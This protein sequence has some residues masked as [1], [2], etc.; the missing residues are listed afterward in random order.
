MS[1]ATADPAPA[2]PGCQRLR[3]CPVRLI[4]VAGADWRRTPPR[5]T[6]PLGAAQHHVARH[7][8]RYSARMSA[9]IFGTAIEGC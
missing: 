6:G 7:D 4:G 3:R 1:P 2:M 5:I 9:D 8:F